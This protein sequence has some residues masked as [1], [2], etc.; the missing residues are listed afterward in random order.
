MTQRYSNIEVTTDGEMIMPDMLRQLS[1]LGM[2]VTSLIIDYVEIGRLTVL[3]LLLDGIVNMHQL[4]SLVLN[5]VTAVRP[6]LISQ[7][8][9]RIQIA[10]LK[11]LAFARSDWLMQCI[12]ADSVDH[13]MITSHEFTRAEE[14]HSI[15]IFLSWLSHVNHLEIIGG[16]V[17][18]THEQVNI[19][20]NWKILTIRQNFATFD[21]TNME[22][23]L[24]ASQQ[25][26]TINCLINMFDENLMVLIN[27][28]SD[29]DSRDIRQLYLRCLRFAR[30]EMDPVENASI[31]N[32]RISF[33]SPDDVDEGSVV[34]FL[35]SFTMVRKCDLILNLPKFVTQIDQNSVLNF[36][37][38]IEELKINQI[39]QVFVNLVFPRVVVIKFKL[40]AIDEIALNFF[41]SQNNLRRIMLG[42][43]L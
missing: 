25:N 4:N 38:S 41:R 42:R 31:E 43:R 10:S 20:F 33:Q 29:I 9:H 14:R 1:S 3:G 6:N 13:L 32:L 27:L 19:R 35:N 22:S 8:R 24:A 17:L 18:I 23:L 11:L 12:L 7:R 30:V 15:I 16:H 39:P 36:V 28:L 5:D 21:M 26:A 37:N 40:P 34:R 2:N